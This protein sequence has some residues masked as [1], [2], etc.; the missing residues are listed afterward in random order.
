MIRCKFC[1]AQNVWPA[2][3]CQQCGAVLDTSPTMSISS[4]MPADGNAAVTPRSP[5]PSQGR[6]FAP[7]SMIGDR[8]R[9]MSLL[10]RGGMGEVYAAEDLKLGQKVALKFLPMHQGKNQSCANSSTPKCAWR[11]RFPIPMFV[12]CMTLGR[13]T[14]SCSSP[15]NLWTGKTWLRCYAAL[16]A[17]PT[18]KR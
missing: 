10:G 15:W 7:G 3:G 12:E 18:T 6:G 2:E 1:G 16:G 14:A 5:R 13:T 8:Y 11:D 17:C 9:V 4:K